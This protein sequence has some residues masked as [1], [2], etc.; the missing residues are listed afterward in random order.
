MIYTIGHEESY[1]RYFQ[2]QKRPLKSGRNERTGYHGG[3]VWKTEEEARK[4]CPEKYQV[5]GVLADWEADTE[6][7]KE[8]D[9]H[10]LLLDAELIQLETIQV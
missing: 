5:Y 7:S 6:P 4:N 9:W 2:E 1:T 8:G 10:D 3:S